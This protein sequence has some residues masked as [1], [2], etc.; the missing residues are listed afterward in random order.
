VR[1]SSD[2]GSCGAFLF[3]SQRINFPLSN[4]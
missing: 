2:W 3:P 1:A 4:E